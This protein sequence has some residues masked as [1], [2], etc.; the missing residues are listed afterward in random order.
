M[1]YVTVIVASIIALSVILVV[2]VLPL[3]WPTAKVPDA[4]TNWGGLIIGFYFGSFVTLLKDWSR[5]SVEVVEANGADT[6]RGDK[7]DDA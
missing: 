3:F 4:L 7:Q 6:A 5:E 1:I 2:A